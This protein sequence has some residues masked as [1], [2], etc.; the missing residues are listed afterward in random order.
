[1]QNTSSAKRRRHLDQLSGKRSPFG[2]GRLV[3]GLLCALLVGGVAAPAMALDK[4]Q[5]VQMSKLGLDSKSIKGAIDSGGA[6]LELTPEELEELKRNGVS[7]DVL[8]HLKRNGHVKGLKK[9]AQAAPTGGIGPAPAPAPSSDDSAEDAEERQRLEKEREAEILKKADELNAQRQ[10]DQKRLDRMAQMAAQLGRAESDLDSGK[11]M[12]AARFYLE[13]LSLGPDAQSE[14]WYRAKFGLAKALI[15]EGILSGATAPLLEVLMAGAEK[16]HFEEAFGLLA[17]LTREI[18]Y[19]PPLIEEFTRFYVQDKSEAFQN[20][21]NYYMG[22]F[23]FDYNR[24]DLALSYLEKVQPGSERYPAALYLMGVVKL[25]PAI[26]KRAEAL[27]HFQNAILAGEAQAKSNEEILQLSYL[28][29]ARVFYEVGLYDVALFYYQKL[30]TNSS[31]HASA[32][33][34]MAW[35]YFMKNDYRR[36][37]G[38]FHTLNSDYYSHW[39]LPDLH[40]LESTV[41]LNLCKFPQSQRSLESFRNRYLEQRPLLQQFMRDTTTPV[42]YWNAVTA[43]RKGKDQGPLP[44]V[45]TQAVLESLSFYNTYQVVKYLSSEK[46]ALE[47]NIKS[48]GEFGQE[49]LDSVNEQLATKIDEGGVLVQQRLTEIDAELQKWDLAAMQISFDIDNEEREQIQQRLV[50]PDWT[51]QKGEGGTTLLIV[52]DDWQPWPFEGEYWRDEVSNY[53]SRLRTECVEK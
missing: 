38:T 19:Q 33:F 4:G 17:R 47:A 26:D 16:R 18:G 20:V 35:S 23:F 5:I 11:N 44:P 7:E 30:P 14:E 12:A 6:D 40:I 27:T 53:R 31:R 46:A 8:E 2:L 1:M 32:V 3:G 36:A 42:D 13:F 52:A 48:L 45:Y 49:V 22:K 15:Q 51:P 28:A 29:L 43:A 25:D 9:P 24:T 50:N 39:F 10:D 37:L 41:Y 34:E 21:F